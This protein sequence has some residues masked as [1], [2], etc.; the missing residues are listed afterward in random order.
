MG[1][2]LPNYFHN[3]LGRILPYMYSSFHK[4]NEYIKFLVLQMLTNG[5]HAIILK[6]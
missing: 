6:L 1:I 2:L 3:G 4:C 5:Q